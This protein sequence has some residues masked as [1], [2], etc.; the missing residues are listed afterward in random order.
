[1]DTV[2]NIQRAIDYIEENILGDL[3]SDTIAS[4]AYM[5]GFH[6]QRLFSALCGI[7]LGEYIRNRRLS[8]AGLEVK[9]SDAKVIDIAFKYGYETPESFSRAFSRFHGV[10]PMAARKLGKI[11]SFARLTVK[12]ILEGMIVMQ[13]RITERGYTVA[14][15][16]PVYLT[17]DMDRTAKWFEDVLGW[18]AG[19][20]VRD[21]D[22][23]PTYGCAMPFDGRLVGLGVTDF[24]GLFLFPGEAA[25]CRIAA[26]G[27]KNIDNLYAHVKKSGWE[28]ISE[29]QDIQMGDGSGKLCVVKT[30]DGCSLMFWG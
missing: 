4:Q 21:E 12:S 5:S 1:M 29:V 20:E 28:D 26:M 30:I 25:Q 10:S 7:T 15:V 22:G 3:K 11:N 6:F 9:N 18:Y 27:V 24:N 17:P 8:Q 13:E 2:T 16:S 14:R 23:N 19:V